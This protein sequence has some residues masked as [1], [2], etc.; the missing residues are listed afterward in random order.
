MRSLGSMLLFLSMWFT[1]SCNA[2]PIAS[3]DSTEITEVDTL[4][5]TLRWSGTESSAQPDFSP[6]LRDF[7]VL[8]TGR[9]SGMT[10][11][12]ANAHGAKGQDPFDVG[13]ALSSAIG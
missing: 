5:L 13:T 8:S 6:L 7:E 2:D 12:S 1:A 11:S 4:Q 3:V 9:K 10:F